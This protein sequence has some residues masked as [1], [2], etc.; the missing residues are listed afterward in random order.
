MASVRLASSRWMMV[1]TSMRICPWNWS[2]DQV[3]QHAAVGARGVAA[4][5]SVGSVLAVCIGTR[6][7][8]TTAGELWMVGFVIAIDPWLRSLFPIDGVWCK[9]MELSM[10][11]PLFASWLIICVHVVVMCVSKFIWVLENG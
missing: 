6:V 5:E 7:P 2:G 4:V 10:L 1:K 9:D 11:H 3:I 8:C